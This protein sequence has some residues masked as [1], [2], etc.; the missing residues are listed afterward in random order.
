MIRRPRISQAARSTRTEISSSP[1]VMELTK[2]VAL[3]VSVSEIG[4]KAIVRVA[5]FGTLSGRFV[6]SMC[7]KR[8]FLREISIFSYGDPA[9]FSPLVFHWGEAHI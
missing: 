7:R 6:V 3:Y 1:D 2:Q 4:V 8:R 5:T 9:I